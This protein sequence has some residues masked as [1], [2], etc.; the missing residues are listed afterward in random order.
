MSRTNYNEV[1]VNLRSKQMTI[2]RITKDNP[3]GGYVTGYLVGD[4]V[5]PLPTRW[6]RLDDVWVNCCLDGRLSD[7]MM[8]R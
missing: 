7:G 4:T 6:A 5:L 2:R 3:H 1:L 8:R